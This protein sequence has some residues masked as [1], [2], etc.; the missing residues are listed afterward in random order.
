MHHG[1][2]DCPVGVEADSDIQEGE[3]PAYGLSQMSEYG[4]VMVALAI[5][6]NFQ[7]T[8]LCTHEIGM[9]LFPHIHS[10]SSP[11][12]QTLKSHSFH[13]EN[14]SRVCESEKQSHP[15]LMPA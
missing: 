5:S 7:Y 15:G 4:S 12:V 10:H 11:L 9:N 13:K 3:Y 8:Y 2:S 1:L 6:F 14:W